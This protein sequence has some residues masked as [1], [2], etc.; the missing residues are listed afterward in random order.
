[1]QGKTGAGVQAKPTVA[2]IGAGVVGL[3]TALQLL[4]RGYQVQLFEGES[5]AAGASSGNAGHFATEQV[6]PLAQAS[7]LWSVPRFLI[8]PLGPLAIRPRALWTERRFFWHYLASMWPARWR[9]S[10]QQLKTLCEASIAAWQHLLSAEGLSAL[11]VQQGNLLVFEGEDAIQQANAQQ[12]HYQAGGVAVEFWDASAVQKQCAGISDTV[13]CA[14]YFPQTG[15][16][17]SPLK[18]C[19][20]LAQAIERRGGIVH[21]ARIDQLQPSA[22]GVTIHG[23]ESSW[24]V[25]EVVLC[26]GVHANELLKPLGLWVPMTA[27]RG[28][29]LQINSSA[30]PPMAVAS[31]NRKMIMT[32]MHG[33]LRLAGTVEFAGIDALPNWQRA[34]ALRSHGEA[35]WPSLR[36]GAEVSMWSG[37]RPTCA[38]SLPV[39]GASG[40][41]GVWLNF[42]HQHLGLTLAAVTGLWLVE[43]MQGYNRVNSL[44]HLSINRF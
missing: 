22:D 30:M 40:V 8:N 29:H 24:H 38:D 33:G 20:A 17:M 42:G 34:K 23:A 41:P 18:L 5:V 13:R 43:A 16:C 37:Q 35:L 36:G 1:M 21:I 44:E 2:V 31:F 3:T 28:Y 6:F 19:Q 15:H 27:E 32:P 14:L 10:H 12:H 11:V 39:V 9:Q 4:Q 25:D 26:T 7:L